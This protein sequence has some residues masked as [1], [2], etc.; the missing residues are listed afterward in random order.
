MTISTY[1]ALE[2]RRAAPSEVLDAL[3]DTLASV[4]VFLCRLAGEDLNSH[5]EILHYQLDK[6]LV[7]YR[8]IEWSPHD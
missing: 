2:E 4:S 5:T 6:A 8:N 1:S 7:K 3:V